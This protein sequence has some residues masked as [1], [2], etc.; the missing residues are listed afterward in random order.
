[1]S[2]GGV[3]PAPEERQPWVQTV[4]GPRVNVGADGGHV[5]IGIYTFDRAGAEELARRFVAACWDA[6]NSG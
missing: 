5:F 6:E 2:A 1:M 3:I 4:E